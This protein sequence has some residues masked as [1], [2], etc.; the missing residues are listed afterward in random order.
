MGVIAEPHEIS[1]ESLT[2]LLGLLRGQ[3]EIKSTNGTDAVNEPQHRF[4]NHF[5]PR[6]HAL[7]ERLQH[8]LIATTLPRASPRVSQMS[9]ATL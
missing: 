9:R 1:F 5:A 8:D 4:S 3:H 2:K 6:A 7:D